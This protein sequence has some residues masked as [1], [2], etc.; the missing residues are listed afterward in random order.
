MK[1]I[2]VLTRV[3]IKG[4][5]NKTNEKKSSKKGKIIL[6]ILVYA[7]IGGFV[8]YMSYECISSLILINQEKI[9]LELCFSAVIWLGIIQAIFTSLNILFFSKDIESLL[10][11]PISPFKIIIAKFNCLI[12]SQY[13]TCF[14]VLV[15]VLIVYGALL[16][17]GIQFYLMSL[18]MMLAFPIIPV[19]LTSLVMIIIMKF[20][21]VVRNKEFIQYLS[22]II[23][24]ALIIALQFF[25]GSIGDENITNAE[26]ANALVS[27]SDTINN[28]TKFFIN[29]KP[30][31][32]SVLEYDNLEGFKNLIILFVESIGIYI[33]AG[34]IVS[35]VYI[36]TA[37]SV[38][39]LG[40][41]RGKKI[42]SS[43]AFLSENISKTYVKKEFKFLIRNPIFFMQCVLPPL[44]FP[45]IFSIPL[46]ASYK[47]AG[48]EKM[49]VYREYLSR[50]DK[51]I[52]WIYHFYRND[53]NNIYV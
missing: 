9:F 19:I 25:C 39:S 42:N 3:L 46:L 53:I 6:Y 40:I 22:V 41:K 51:Y 34:I 10:P 37:T 1:D 52:F 13:F 4:L 24:M 38:T 16:K 2:F 26:L 32:N 47:N 28:S 20:I 29:L 12:F 15:P 23:M 43:K 5:F 31:I 18:L 8:G 7:Y 30:A 44:I 17:Y 27:K 48:I 33:F 49:E 14:T 36:K 45:F 21:K 35:K 50:N 11:L